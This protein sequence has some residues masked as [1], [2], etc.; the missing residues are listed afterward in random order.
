ML[1]IS[2]GALWAIKKL[3]DNG[4]EAYCVGG[5]IR[6]L[7]MGREVSDFDIT[8]N[9]TP[10]QMKAVFVGERIFETG[11]KHGTLTVVFEKEPLEITTYR[12]DGEYDD[13]RHPKSVEFASALKDDLSRRDF[14]VNALAYDPISDTLVDLFGGINDIKNQILRAIGVPQERFTEDALRILRGARFSSQLGFEIEPETKRAMLE[15][16]PLLENISKERIAIEIN[17]LV[18]GKNAKNA[19]LENCELLAFVIPEI[20]KMNGFDQKNSWHI[21]D[22]LTHTACVV[23]NTPPILHLRLA[24]LLHDVGKVYTFTVDDNGV[25]H[26][27]RHNAVSEKIARAFFNEYKYDNLTKDKCCN[28]ISVHDTHIEADKIYIKKRLNRMGKE[29][30]FDLIIIQRADNLSQNPE[31]VNMSHFDEVE[32]LANEILSEQECFSLKNLAINGNDLIAF[33]F[34]AGRQIGEILA[35]LLSEVIE[36]RIQN[37]KQSLLQLAKA[38][39]GG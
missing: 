1:N 32:R 34:S 17:K 37:E 18:C 19:I 38:K 28:L 30:F 9:A 22:I 26:F 23:D 24:A 7:L 21:Y 10:E 6:D 2:K 36:E 11:I 31:K 12:K 35:F 13:N 33:G 16:A 27:Y 5:S 15:C 3:K 29:A 14:T 8:T 39:F 4:Y 25:G 20:G